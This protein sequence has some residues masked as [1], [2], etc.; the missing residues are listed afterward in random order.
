MPSVIE[1]EG[2]LTLFK[3]MERTKAKD[4]TDKEGC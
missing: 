2:R 3:G 1:P 4:L